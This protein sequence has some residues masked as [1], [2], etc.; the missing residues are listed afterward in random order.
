MASPELTKRFGTSVPRYGISTAG[1]RAFIKQHENVEFDPTTDE[2][3]EK[4]QGGESDAPR[5]LRFE[6]LTTAQVVH[7]IIKP[8]TVQHGCSYAELL[9]Q[10]RMGA[11]CFGS[12]L[13][14]RLATHTVAT[15]HRWVTTR[16]TCR[17]SLQPP[18]SCR[19]PGLMFS[20]TLWPL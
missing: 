19:M 2:L 9:E 13:L 10:A 7:R 17:L 14:L 1:L 6:E 5:R 15:R 4:K 8:A 11:T 3:P 12:A 16:M 18:C 20:R